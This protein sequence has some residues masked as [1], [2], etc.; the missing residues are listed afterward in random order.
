MQAH[1][2]LDITILKN[3]SVQN[4]RFPQQSIPLFYPFDFAGEVKHS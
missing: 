3:T 1:N 4:T 2:A